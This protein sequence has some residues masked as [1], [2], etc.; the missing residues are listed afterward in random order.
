[1]II[2]KYIF[3]SIY[4]K[5]NMSIEG[6]EPSPFYRIAPEATALDRSA[7]LTTLKFSNFIEL[8]ENAKIYY[9]YLLY[10]YIYIFILVF[11]FFIRN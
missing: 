8:Y 4:N 9:I 2:I 10:I 3:S 11:I 1:M 6:F 5:K 7:K